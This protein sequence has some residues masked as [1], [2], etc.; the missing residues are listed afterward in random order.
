MARS[1]GPASGSR[2]DNRRN[3][4]LSATCTA[5]GRPPALTSLTRITL[6]DTH[7]QTRHAIADLA[8]REPQ[9]GRG[10]GAVVAV[11]I[12]CAFEDVALNTVQVDLQVIRQGRNT[13]E[14]V[15]SR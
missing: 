9:A 10:G 3:K 6:V 15:L 2:L 7:P 8:Q 12:E 5:T 11:A 1:S 14:K 4:L 13:A